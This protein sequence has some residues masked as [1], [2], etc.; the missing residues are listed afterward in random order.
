MLIDHPGVWQTRW[1]AGSV[2]GWTKETVLSALYQSRYLSD[3]GRLF[4]DSPDKLVPADVDAK[5]NVYEYEPEGLGS[6]RTTTANA[7]AV[8]DAPAQGCVG[9]ISSGASSEE[10][11]FL[12]ASAAGPGGEEAEDVFFV[13]NSQ[14]S[15]QDIDSAFDVYDAHVCTDA[16][17]CPPTQ[18]A[19]T[20]SACTTSDSCRAAPEPQPSIFGAPPSATFSGSGNLSPPA[21]AKVTVKPPTRAQKLAAALKACHRNR[22]RKKRA[23]CERQVRKQYGTP[24]KAATQKANDKRRRK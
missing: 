9:L 24:K 22:S 8:Y 16:S 12:D 2:P 13:T 1:L 5:E 18:T 14:L 6:C 21:P 11:A 7:G 17:P 19:P 23:R 4:F 15:P 10:S 3:S 20:P